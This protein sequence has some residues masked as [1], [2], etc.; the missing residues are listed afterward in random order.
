MTK[1]T[2]R[3]SPF[4]F[5]TLQILSEIIVSASSVDIEKRQLCSLS[6]RRDCDVR[7]F[8][9]LAWIRSSSS[10][11]NRGR[12]LIGLQSEGSDGS[13]EFLSTGT[14]DDR[15]QQSG[16]QEDASHLLYSL[17]KQVA[18]SVRPRHQEIKIAV[19]V[20]HHARRRFLRRSC[21]TITSF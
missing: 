11:T 21:S 1:E 7:Y 20:K 18:S 9:N 10:F 14:T 16:K 12:R 4:L 15:F 17:E 19:I 5:R 6:D 2:A 8:T 3:A 13:L